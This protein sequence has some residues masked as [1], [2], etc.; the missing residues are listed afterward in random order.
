MVALQGIATTMS[1]KSGGSLASS[2][3]TTT[4][5][6][7][8]TPRS[9]SLRSWQDSTMAT[10]GDDNDDDDNGDGYE[11]DEAEDDEDEDEDKEGGC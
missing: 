6:P 11:G 4:S 8:L 2:V 5:Q 10:G 9:R 7:L 1:G 3:T